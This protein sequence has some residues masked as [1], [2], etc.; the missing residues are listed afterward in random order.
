MSNGGINNKLIQRNFTATKLQSRLKIKKN[1]EDGVLIEGADSLREV[2]KFF[3]SYSF[4]S[5]IAKWLFGVDS[6]DQYNVKRYLEIARNKLSEVLDLDQLNILDELELR[7]EL[8]KLKSSRLGEFIRNKTEISEGFEFLE[9]KLNQPSTD[10]NRS[11]VAKAAKLLVE[12]NKEELSPEEKKEIVNTNFGLEDQLTGSQENVLNELIVKYR[13]IK[14]D[15]D[16]ARNQ[17]L[18]DKLIQKIITDKIKDINILKADVDFNNLS[19]EFSERL[20]NEFVVNCEIRKKIISGQI[21]DLTSLE[22]DKDFR[23][24]PQGIKGKIK[25]EFR[26]Y[27]EIKV[28]IFTEQIINIVSLED[29]IDF[30]K[31]SKEIKS[32]VKDDFSSYLETSAQIITEQIKDKEQLEQ[33]D[34][35]KGLSDYLKLKLRVNLAQRISA[36]TT[37]QREFRGF[38]ETR[39]EKLYGILIQ[40]ITAGEI[41]DIEMLEEDISFQKLSKEYKS[42]IKS[43]FISYLE[44]ALDML[45]GQLHDKEQL[46]LDEKYKKL[47]NP[48]QLKLQKSLEQRVS[49]ATTIQKVYRGFKVR[50]EKLYGILIQKINAGEITDIDKLE[51]DASFK[52]LSKE[53]KSKIKSEFISY[54]EVAL[55]ML[56]GQLHDKEQLVLNEKYKILPNPLQLKLQKSLE[57]RVNAASIIQRTFNNHS[58]R[59]KFLTYQ[60]L[61]SKVIN[62]EIEDSK[63]L[64]ADPENQKLPKYFQEL[65]LQH[66]NRI[67]QDQANTITELKMEIDRNPKTSLMTLI[68]SPKFKMLFSKNSQLIVNYLN[69]RR[70][71][72]FNTTLENQLSPT[73]SQELY[74]YISGFSE[75]P[76]GQTIYPPQETVEVAKL[77]SGAEKAEGEFVVIAEDEISYILANKVK[78][79]S[80]PGGKNKIVWVPKGSSVG[81]VIVR[82]ANQDKI[83]KEY[84]PEVMFT[85]YISGMIGVDSEAG[86]VVGRLISTQKPH[87]SIV[88]AAQF[89]LYD[90]EFEKVVNGKI[91]HGG[92]TVLN[93]YVKSVRESNQSLEVKLSIAKQLINHNFKLW[94]I[95]TKYKIYH[96]DWHANNL[97]ALVDDENIIL[98]KLFDFGS[99]GCGTSYSP[100]H[101]LLYFFSASIWLQIRQHQGTDNLIPTT[102]QELVSGLPKYIFGDTSKEAFEIRARRNVLFTLPAAIFVNDEAYKKWEQLSSEQIFQKYFNNLK[103]IAKQYSN[104]LRRDEFEIWLNKY[105]TKMDEFNGYLISKIELVAHTTYPVRSPHTTNNPEEV[106][107][108]GEPKPAPL[109]EDELNVSQFEVVAQS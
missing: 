67:W 39:N 92:Y 35:F 30:N 59:N 32:R 77:F 75:T 76:E 2:A 21:I 12:K 49:A 25:G 18:Y 57:Q 43:E 14:E 94:K 79:N 20:R 62:E 24:L 101:D 87:R 19:A 108:T 40:K 3:F 88:G 23:E 70:I 50:N 69:K 61:H 37:I 103:D 29:D 27:S 42:K 9:N 102:L 48:L 89:S 5:K 71:E 106:N 31:L 60:V 45:A 55:D 17:E 99:A 80:G 86:N 105:F 41:T 16:K 10:T 7:L 11:V 78:D 100:I 90:T 104:D 95:M 52:K 56:A 72:A 65:V 34:K 83:T 109:V 26:S 107:N 53:Y 82:G 63:M 47:P 93:E 74:N 38:N 15:V 28:K 33:N 64:L 96:K 36:A 22:K 54:L 97:K 68:T 91:E 98:M 6:I 4:L 84:G 8:Q 58:A 81:Y 13:Q 51:E 85:K 66:F 73:I 1:G 44:V 46:V